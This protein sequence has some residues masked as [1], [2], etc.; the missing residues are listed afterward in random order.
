MDSNS[1]L[2]MKNVQIYLYRNDQQEGPYTEDQLREMVASGGVTQ[3]EYAWHE[4]LPEWQHLNTLIHFSPRTNKASEGSQGQF[5][6][7]Q[8]AMR[9]REFHDGDADWGATYHSHYDALAQI[10][11]PAALA[12]VAKEAIELCMRQ[13]AVRRITDQKVLAEVGMNEDFAALRK[14]A[15][16]RLTDPAALAMIAKG[17]PSWDDRRRAVWKVTDQMLLT[18]IA[19]NDSVERVRKEA[20][21]RVTDR[22]LLAEIDSKKT[23][24]PS[25]LT[26]NIQVPGPDLELAQHQAEQLRAAIGKDPQFTQVKVSSTDNGSVVVYPPDELPTAAK[27]ELEKM[28]QLQAPVGTQI[29]Y[30]LKKPSFPK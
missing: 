22:S 4:G 15:C 6:L 20:Y 17:A 29:F 19:I 10:T 30:P 28:I 18:D 8:I 11:D 13:S 5:A 2:Q 21:A 27:T 12:L 7:A 3:T 16:D 14:E 25:S 26:L 9:R 1:D 23:P 24:S